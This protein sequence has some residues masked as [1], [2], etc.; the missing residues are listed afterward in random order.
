MSNVLLALVGFV[1]ME[2][3]SYAVH[4]WVMHGIGYGW[5]RSHHQP[6]QGRFE[7]NDRFPIV[8][9]V[10]GITL[11]VLG[12]W[13]L[14][15]LWWLAVGVTAY[16]V[17]YMVVHDGFIHRRLPV[18]VPRSAYFDWLRAAHRD[19]HTGGGEPYGMLAPL[20]R[21]P[22]SGPADN[23]ADGPVTTGRCGPDPLDRSIRHRSSRRAGPSNSKQGPL[24]PGPVVAL[25]GDERQVDE[26]AVAPHG[27]HAGPRIPDH[28]Q[29]TDDHRQPVT[30]LGPTG[31]GG[32]SS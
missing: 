25:D 15:A 28:G 27:D 3:V 24:D 13:W 32:E 8:F 7:A 12:T 23:G 1:G 21:R 22:G 17:L 11:F 2:A 30:A 29:R 6:R 14:S 31:L 4:R 26:H 18:P 19:H 10:I 5:H 20:V 16:G 9:S